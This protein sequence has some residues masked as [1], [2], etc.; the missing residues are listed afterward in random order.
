MKIFLVAALIVCM[1]VALPGLEASAVTVG[2]YTL[3]VDIGKVKVFQS[4]SLTDCSYNSGALAAGMSL[5]YIPNDGVYLSGTPA[6]A[7]S[8]YASYNVTTAVGVEVLNINFNVVNPAVAT[9]EPTYVPVATPEPQPVGYAPKIT[10]HPTGETV[11]VG[12]TAKFIARADNATSFT[13]RLVSADTTCTYKASEGSYYF[14]GLEVS[15]INSDTLILSNIPASLSGWCVECRF[16]NAYGA[17]YSNGARVTV[18]S[19]NNAGT[20]KPAATQAPASNNN[21]QSQPQIQEPAATEAPIVPGEKTANINIQPKGKIAEKGESVTLTVQATSP[22]NG[23]LSYQW[24]CAPVKDLNAALPI[25]GASGES[26]TAEAAEG[27][28]FYW[29]AIWNT[30]EGRRSEAIYTEPAEVAVIPEVTPTP[31]P[32]PTPAPVEDG[33]SFLSS[34]MQLV[35][36]A[37][38]GLLA[39]A[40]LIG[41]VIFLRIESKRED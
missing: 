6:S 22:N 35:L 9:P 19:K 20:Q 2:D 36:F 21:T 1:S 34:N 41:V 39:L 29:C 26:F 18:E 8:Y 11:E 32:T 5:S 15:G 28:M 4:D 24:Y 38:I 16:D 33:S 40:A 12:G 14:P 37:V 10:K 13:W 23:E 30:R 3:G 25:G 7:G 31:E 17:S 27:S